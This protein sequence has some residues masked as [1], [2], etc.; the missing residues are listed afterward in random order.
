MRRVYEKCG[1]RHEG[2]ARRKGYRDG[3]WHDVEY[4]GILREDWEAAG[5]A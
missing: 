2:T 4:Y 1:Y 5:S 3:T